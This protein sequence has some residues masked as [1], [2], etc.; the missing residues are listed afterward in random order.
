MAAPYWRRCAGVVGGKVKRAAHDADQVGAGGGQ[1]EAA[2]RPRGRRAERTGPARRRGAAR[3]E[4]HAGERARQVDAALA[5]CSSSGDATP[6]V[7]PSAPA[8]TRADDARSLRRAPG[9]GVDRTR[10]DATASV[11]EVLPQRDRLGVSAAARRRAGAARRPGSGRETARR[12][13]P[14]RAPRRRSR[15]RPPRPTASPVVGRRAELAPARAADRGVE[16]GHPLGVVERGD[17]VHDPGDRPPGPPRRARA[18]CSGERRTSIRR[19]ARRRQCRGPLVT[20]GAAQHLARGRPR[21]GVD[22]DDV[23]Q[24]LVGGQRVGDELLQL[25]GA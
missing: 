22:H 21:N 5:S 19:A 23:V 4:R 18:T 11:A 25:L 15:P 8:S 17:A 9:P 12:P 20:Q 1:T 6:M 16:L 10:R 3:R 13:V 2:A 14:G 7:Q 24:P